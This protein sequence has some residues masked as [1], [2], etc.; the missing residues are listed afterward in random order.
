M[1]ENTEKKPARYNYQQIRLDKQTWLD[2]R[3]TATSKG[4]KSISEY[5][6]ALYHK[7]IGVE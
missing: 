2:M 4:Y 6:Q 3:A 7:D 5:I 1:I